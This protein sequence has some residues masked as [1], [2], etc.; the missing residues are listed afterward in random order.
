MRQC[1]AGFRLSFLFKNKLL[2]GTSTLAVVLA[3]HLS[4][5][6]PDSTIFLPPAVG[7]VEIAPG[8]F[9]V[10]FN[11]GPDIVRTFSPDG[12]RLL[13]RSSGLVGFGTEWRILSIPIKGR[14][15]TEEAALYRQVLLAPVGNIEFNDEYRILVL[16]RP[17]VPPDVGG[18]GNICPLRLPTWELTMLRLEP[19]DG[20]PLSALPTRSAILPVLNS[21]PDTNVTHDVS[22]I[23]AQQEIVDFLADPFGP[24]MLPGSSIG[25]YSDGETLWRFDAADPSA[26]PELVGPGAF[27]SLSPDGKRLAAAV[28]TGTPDTAITVCTVPA[29]ISCVEWIRDIRTPGWLTIVYDVETGSSDTIASGLEPIFDLTGERL[30]VRRTMGFFWVDL[31]TGGEEFVPLTEGGFAPALSSDGTLLAFSSKMSGN[32]D[33]Y[34]VRLR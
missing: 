19:S 16:W 1:I 31:D 11:E 27:P 24:T 34:L 14:T 15:V 3:L 22:I 12:S 7:P 9:R 23:P 32:I 13:Y 25:I 6:T 5:S 18:C 8:L 2:V 28:P 33:V 21:N 17:P 20:A 10:T 4:C 26:P 30:L 29:L